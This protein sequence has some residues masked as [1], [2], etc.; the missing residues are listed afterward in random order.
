MNDQE[1]FKDCTR[2]WINILGINIQGNDA[3]PE[4]VELMMNYYCHLYDSE[5]E[6]PREILGLINEIF[7]RYLDRKAN[8]Q[9]YGAMDAAFGFT[10]KQGD[11][12][13]DGRN[14]DIAADVARHWMGGKS[15]T[16]AVIKVTAKRKLGRTTVTNAWNK[17]K[18]FALVGVE[19]EYREKQIP[20]NANKKK[21]IEKEKNKFD[22]FLQDFLKKTKS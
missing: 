12:N 1:K 8:K 15:I 16:N 6:I 7:K 3:Q 4:D 21:L 14:M 11:R 22:K 17:N 13:I 18:Y 2:T 5:D 9:F 10:R 19:N 20:I